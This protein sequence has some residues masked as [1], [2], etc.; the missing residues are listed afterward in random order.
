MTS[1]PDTPHRDPI[2]DEP[3][4]DAGD[5]Q[6]SFERDNFA[7][8]DSNEQTLIVQSEQLLPSPPT[9]LD[10]ANLFES[11]LGTERRNLTTG[12]LAIR[13]DRR[14]GV[15]GGMEPSRRGQWR[16]RRAFAAASCLEPDDSAG[17]SA[18]RPAS[19]RWRSVLFCK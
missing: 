12:A 7:S 19:A 14:S 11:E 5:P 10:S 2:D 6:V 18:L 13:Y 9:G 15:V 8:L 4:F 16:P 1:D 3:S 17:C